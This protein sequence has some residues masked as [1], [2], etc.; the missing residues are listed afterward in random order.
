MKS[1]RF[2][3]MVFQKICLLFLVVF[4][5][6]MPSKVHAG[7]LF[8]SS[9]PVQQCAEGVQLFLD[10]KYDEA[11]PLLEAGFAHRSE[12]VFPNP[13]D[14]GYCA[15]AFG[16]IHIDRG[17]Y[18]EAIDIYQVSREIFV[19]S[20]DK[21]DELTSLETIAHMYINLKQYEF[22]IEYA[23]QA[24]KI[25]RELNDYRSEFQQLLV[26]GDSYY[27][28]GELSEALTQY[29]QMLLVSRNAVDKG[30]E[31]VALQRVGAIY[32]DQNQYAESIK[33]YQAALLIVQGA[34]DRSNEAHILNM[35]GMI[36][37]EMKDYPTALGHFKSS[38]AIYEDLNDLAG[39]TKVLNNIAWM[40]KDQKQYGESLKYY[41][42]VLAVYREAGNR[43]GESAVLGNIAVMYH[44]QGLLAD[45]LVYFQKAS[46]IYRDLGDQSSEASALNMVGSL[47][48]ELGRYPE[49][50]GYLQQSL[51]SMEQANDRVGMALVQYNLGAVYLE[52]GQYDKA[53]EYLQHSLTITKDGGYQEFEVDTLNRTGMVYHSLGQKDM[54]LEYFL[55]S[56][57]AGKK[58]GDMKNGGALTNVANMF[59]EVGLY[60]KSLE[61]YQQALAV[62]RKTGALVEEGINLNNIGV[63]HED[64]GKIVEALEYYQQALT[65]AQQTG[66][67]SSEGTTLNNIGGAYLDLEKYPE[68]LEAL[69]KALPIIR[70]AGDRWG[71]GITLS[72][73]GATYE[74]QGDN[75]K[76][77][78]FFEHSIDVFESLRGSAG[79]EKSRSTFI[80][81]HSDLYDR[82]IPLYIQD[83]QFG[84]AFFATERGRARSFLDS[85]SAGYIELDGSE[86]NAL[87]AKEQEAYVARRQA[88]NALVQG[89]A[90]NPTD[91]ELIA[92][93]E[94]QLNQAEQNYQI[95]LDAISARADHLSQLVP[96]RVL[97]VAQVQSLLDDETVLLSFWVTDDKT[98]VFVI[99]QN[100]LD[101]VELNVL[102]KDLYTQIEAFRS[103]VNTDSQYP[104]T[105]TQLYKLIIEPLKPHLI[106]S[107]LVIIPHQELHYLPF[108]AL[109]DG[110]HY[111]VDDYSITYLPSA[112]ALPFIKQ[113][114]DGNSNALFV[115]GNP[116]TDYPDLKPLPYAESES[117]VIA[118]MYQTTP[119]LGKDATESALYRQSPEAGIIHLA[120]HGSYN[121]A[122]PLHSGL[123][124]AP[125]IEQDG[126]LETREIYKL[127]LSN[128]NLVVLSACQT[129][130]GKLSTGDEMVGMT[131][132]FLFAGTPTVISSLWEVDDKA[133]EL[134]MEKFYGNWRN[135]MSKEEALR[136]AQIEIRANYPNPYYWA[137]F[138]LNGDGGQ[139]S[140]TIIQPEETTVSAKTSLIPYYLSGFLLV[141]LFVVIVSVVRNRK[142]NSKRI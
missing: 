79:N 58:N 95:A 133:T 127:N 39:R 114:A 90:R 42:Q 25:S 100:S 7:R 103:F 129:Q 92:K 8:Q 17:E 50:L 64:Q 98:F 52:M 117:K 11:F 134:L 105:S 71:E 63:L 60:E 35:F 23:Q 89:K 106:K 72:N 135:G 61:Y 136:Q 3:Y 115:L 31:S 48:G 16:R 113:N 112:S 9:D 54:A 88:Q 101:V 126:L 29:E 10:S 49:A 82:V 78:E 51:I 65:I 5:I 20:G 40:L 87:Y 99:T 138:V 45:A 2:L 124:L 1:N 83:K 22:A 94:G 30:R 21:E 77:L 55:Q 62:N 37:N 26:I 18:I 81:Q 74:L 104:D 73:L 6:F 128:A 108:A 27:F 97:D 137:G 141:V 109:T 91:K 32:L 123:Y 36:H 85:L 24:L 67:L 116:A 84:E 41:E 66:N 122:N 76:S 13:N 57:E 4:I 38:L 96:S 107:H 44:Q 139:G 14:L 70:E 33:A 111:L 80:D 34:G 12:V 28:N 43:S 142:K 59:S 69:E 120:V 46:L 125:D 102:R 86:A 110:S 75:S 93:L 19:K 68:A 121:S 56:I 140:E 119:L 130:L 132:A 118:A 53:L 15:M 47:S 131:R